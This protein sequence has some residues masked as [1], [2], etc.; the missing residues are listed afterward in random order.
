MTV[1]LLSAVVALLGGCKTKPAPDSGFLSQP[2]LMTAQRERFP[3]DRVWVRPGVNWDYYRAILVRP[4]NTAYL[5]ENTGWK[6]ANPGNKDL[7]EDAQELADFTHD[8]FVEA[9][10]ADPHHRLPVS[11]RK[12]PRVAVLDIAIVELVPSK[13]VLGALGLVAPLAG[14]AAVGVGSKVAG[15]N[16][17]VAIEGRVYDSQ[18]G[19]VLMMFADRE[20]PPFRILDAKAVT[21]YG[22]AEDSIKIWARQMVELA[23]TPRSQKV[24]DASSF[25]LSPW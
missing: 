3:F 2:D 19:A 12:G 15:G 1:C 24:D 22:D 5:M 23:N 16:P 11:W 20:E 9:F 10:D 21:W 14:S 4:V 18:T 17:S 6:A 7:T 8:S 13:A 25:S